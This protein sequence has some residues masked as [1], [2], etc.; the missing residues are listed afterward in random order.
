MSTSILIHEILQLG[1]QGELLG[2]F[3]PGNSVAVKWTVTAKPPKKQPLT[4]YKV[5]QLFGMI[6][7]FIVEDQVFFFLSLKDL[8]LFGRL[9]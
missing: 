2:L 1:V 4:W 6:K 7:Y 5:V 8:N 9:S 3:K